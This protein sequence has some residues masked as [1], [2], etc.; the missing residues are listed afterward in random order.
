MAKQRKVETSFGASD[1]YFENKY[2]FN[3]KISNVPCGFSKAKHNCK[4][5][6]PKSI[7]GGGGFLNFFSFVWVSATVSFVLLIIPRPAFILRDFLGFMYEPEWV[8]EEIF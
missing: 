3:I 4:L 5:R 1:L 6:K 7:K 8:T 2:K